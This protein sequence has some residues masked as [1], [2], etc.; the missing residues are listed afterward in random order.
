[1]PENNGKMFAIGCKP[2]TDSMFDTIS[3]DAAKN[4][5]WPHKKGEANH[6]I[7]V[8]AW[9]EGETND[10]FWIAEMKRVLDVLSRT[11][12][13]NLPVYANTALAEHTDVKDIYRDNL[14]KLKT[15]RDTV[16]PTKVM[17]LAGGFKIPVFP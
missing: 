6:F 12:P 10:S 2:F 14:E 7:L 9:W 8:Y 16:D 11:T 5:A 13:S 1:M 4:G 3:T 17:S 15:I